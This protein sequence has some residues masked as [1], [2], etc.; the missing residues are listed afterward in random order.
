MMRYSSP[1]SLLPQWVIKDPVN[2]ISA[3]WQLSQDWTRPEKQRNR[4]GISLVKHNNE[5][6]DCH[7]YQNSESLLRSN[8]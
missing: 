5:K 1:P 6:V 7:G 3:M 2:Q 4:Q 8:M